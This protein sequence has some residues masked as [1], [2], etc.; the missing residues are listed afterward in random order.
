[1]V[2]NSEFLESGVS[3]VGA[4]KGEKGLYLGQGKG[5]Y[6]DLSL[7]RSGSSTGLT[8]GSIPDKEP[9]AIVTVLTAISAE[10]E[11]AHKAQA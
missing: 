8:R 4:N 3:G 10:R 2:R 9:H 1:M 5:L 11:A 7:E 6:L